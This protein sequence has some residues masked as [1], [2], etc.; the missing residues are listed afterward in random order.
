MPALRI[1]WLP[2]AIALL[3]AYCAGGGYLPFLL[4]RSS[5]R[6][7]RRPRAVRLVGIDAAAM[8]TAGFVVWPLASLCLLWGIG[9]TLLGGGAL[10][11]AWL[12]F[13]LTIEVAGG[14]TVVVRRVAWLVRWSRSVYPATAVAF[15]D[16]W[17]DFADPEALR[18]ELPGRAPLELAWSDAHSGSRCEDLAAAFNAHVHDLRG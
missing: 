3:T 14:Q 10:L 4:A 5:I 18:L 1:D 6:I 11:M 7:H 8:F 12:G 16:G 9:A 2:G 17:G 13:R 15:T